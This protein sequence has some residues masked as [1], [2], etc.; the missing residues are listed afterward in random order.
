MLSLL[1]VIE[2]RPLTFLFLDG[3]NVL[4]KLLAT[5]KLFPLVGEHSADSSYACNDKTHS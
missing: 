1:L 4:V 5:G 3:E 2:E